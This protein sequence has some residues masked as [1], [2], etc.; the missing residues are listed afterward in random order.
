MARDT[1]FLDAV[2]MYY[3]KNTKR[4]VNHHESGRVNALHRTVWGPGVTT[5][6][7][8][9][10]YV[11]DRLLQVIQEIASRFPTPLRVLALGCGVG[12]SLFYLAQR[13]P[14]QALGITLSPVQVALA[15][16]K[17][18]ALQLDR[19]CRFIEADFLT[20]P[21]L[22]PHTTVFAIESFVHCP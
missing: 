12:S 9:F 3:D 6:N 15:T 22:E 14:I 17:A 21:A 7:E 5:Q 1:A 18:R 10:L 19:Q 2:R 13:L 8:A 11:N 4:F 20:L 16:Q